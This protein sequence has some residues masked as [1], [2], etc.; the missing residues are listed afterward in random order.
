MPHFNKEVADKLIAIMCSDFEHKG[1]V[2]AESDTYSIDGLCEIVPDDYVGFD[3]VVDDDETIHVYGIGAG[4]W[5][6]NEC[7]PLGGSDE[8]YRCTVCHRESTAKEWNEAT[9][10][11]FGGKIDELESHDSDDNEFTCPACYRTST[12]MAIV[13]ETNKGKQ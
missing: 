4:S 7:A 12:K 1:L 9:L 8:L 13:E 3:I 11:D 2:C 6:W 5:C 10:R